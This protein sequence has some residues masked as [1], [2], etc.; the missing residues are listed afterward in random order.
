V[1]QKLLG[2][3]FDLE[4]E[5][6]LIHCDNQIC[7]KLTKNHVFHNRSNHIEIKYHYIWYMLERIYV[8]LPYISTSEQIADTLTKPLLRVNYE[9]F[10][11][12]IGVFLNV[13]S[14]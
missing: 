14:R 9:Y 2:G 13:D 10:G 8:E 6:T 4:L 1:L 5:S 3:I 12:K 11:D 7:V